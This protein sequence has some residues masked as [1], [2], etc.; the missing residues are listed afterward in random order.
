[1]PQCDVSKSSSQIRSVQIWESSQ[2]A[3][4]TCQNSQRDALKH[5]PLR[6]TV[7]D[8]S[9]QNSQRASHKASGNPEITLIKTTICVRMC[10]CVRMYWKIIAFDIVKCVLRDTLCCHGDSGNGGI[11]EPL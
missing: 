7:Q 2:S 6:W 9:S 3:C 5:Q 8:K 4:Q 1:M 11:P 10:V